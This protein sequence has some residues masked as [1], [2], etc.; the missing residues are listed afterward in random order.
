[1]FRSRVRVQHP[2]SCA[3]RRRGA[4][5]CALVRMAVCASAPALPEMSSGRS[6]GILVL[7]LT[8]TINKASD[9]C[10]VITTIEMCFLRK[11]ILIQEHLKIREILMVAR[12]LRE[13]L[14]NR[15]MLGSIAPTG[16]STDDFKLK[17]VSHPLRTLCKTTRHTFGGRTSSLRTNGRRGIDSPDAPPARPRERAYGNRFVNAA[18]ANGGPD[19]R[20]SYF[21]FSVQPKT[22]VFRSEYV[23]RK[24]WQRDVKNRRAPGEPERWPL[25]SGLLEKKTFFFGS[26]LLLSSAAARLADGEAGAAAHTAKLELVVDYQS[27]LLAASGGES[28]LAGRARR[29]RRA[30]RAPYNIQACAAR[31]SR[32]RQRLTAPPASRCKYFIIIGTCSLWALCKLYKPNFPV[33][34]WPTLT[35]P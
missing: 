16:E 15:Q 12:W 6:L 20:S 21:G 4:M 14:R 31:R 24:S 1:M 26:P 5:R 30:R 10:D 9:N 8:I 32:M 23:A 34:D 22:C 25:A 3:V 27:R 11:P 17:Y 7:E 33:Y 29:A 28:R 19:G 35:C 2:T 18:A 13:S